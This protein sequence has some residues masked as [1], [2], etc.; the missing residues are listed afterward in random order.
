MPGASDRRRFFLDVLR[1]AADVVRE[2]SQAIREELDP[3]LLEAGEW[4][5]EDQWYAQPPVAATPAK[6]TLVPEELLSLCAEVGLEE[7]AQDVI[8]LARLSIRLTRAADPE[9]AAPRSRLG[10]VPDLP[11]GF[12]WPSWNGIELAFLGQIDLAA[13]AA[14]APDL[15]LPGRGLLLF[16]YEASGQPSG[17]HPAH[18]GSC[19]V[20]HLDGDPSRLR[21]APVERASFAPYPVALS[22]ELMLP[23]SW[24]PAVEA[25]DLDLDERAAWDD[26][27]EKVA[28]AQGVELE[29]LV[30]RWQSLHRLLGYPEELGSGIELDCQLASAGIA[31]DD[32]DSVLDP[33]RD[34]L[35]AGAIAW[36]LLL[37]VSDDEELGTSWG[38]GFGRVWILM[39]EEDLRKRAFDRAW[40]ILR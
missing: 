30:P 18:R 15:P 34:E 17:L 36:R 33:R 8:R 3:G 24:S 5:E 4:S 37:Q 38:Q 20:V 6:R 7:R 28:A 1:E 14:L 35:E 32:A 13:V 21:P 22:G 11:S 25:L 23:P 39:R 10:G 2:V 27:R 29:D 9:A 16:F 19:R 31:V 26:L 40:A 12:E